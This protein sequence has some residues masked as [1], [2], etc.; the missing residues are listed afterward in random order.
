MLAIRLQGRAIEGC[1]AT[2]YGSENI[3]AKIAYPVT[4][5]AGTTTAIHAT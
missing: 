5:V 2:A 4:N 1:L 3:S